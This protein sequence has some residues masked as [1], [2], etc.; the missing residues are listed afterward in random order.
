MDQPAEQET[1]RKRD[2][3]PVVQPAEQG[4]RRRR[5]RQPVDQPAEQETRRKKS[6]RP[7]D[8]LAEQGTR[9]K[10][11][12]GS[13]CGYPGNMSGYLSKGG[14]LDGIFCVS[15]AYHGSV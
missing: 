12:L 8:Q 2:Q 10:P 4:I 15:M 3:Q 1:K 7:V 6:Q 13:I 9:N 5:D 14:D 11:D